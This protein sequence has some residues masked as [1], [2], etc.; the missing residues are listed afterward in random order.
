MIPQNRPKIKSWSVGELGK[1]WGQLKGASDVPQAFNISVLYSTALV[2]DFE[3][4]D[5]FSYE[6]MNVARVVN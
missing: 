6:L 4:F 1:N 5:P 2:G 3:L